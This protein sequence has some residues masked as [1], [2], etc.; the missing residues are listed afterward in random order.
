MSRRPVR[1]GAVS[2]LNSRPLVAGLE[3]YP[4]RF[5]VR[6]DVPSACARL[7]HAR[8]TDVG[9][10]P[11]IEYLRGD[12]YRMVPDCAVTSDGPVRSVAIF[13]S[14]PIERVTSLALDTS[15]RTSVALTRVLSEHYF[16]IRPRLVE[17]P[18]VL[19]EMVRQADGALLIGEPALF[20]EYERLGLEKI[21]LG[22]AW[23]QFS[24]LPFVYA[25]WT[26][27]PGALTRDDVAT[28]QEA[29][30]RGVASVDEVA[31]RFFPDDP[32]RAA[33]GAVYLRENIHFRLGP[34]EIAGMER[35]FELAAAT[36]VVP[37]TQPL[38]WYDAP[39]G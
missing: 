17:H 18:P 3:A 12:G 29:R 21:D 14:V 5:A 1:I 22:L 4:E 36:G 35:F 34:R 9:L 37:A 2:Y 24:G 20:A 15:S 10:I 30:A 32:D 11:S 25:C 38:R 19:D 7:L 28:L 27:H 39:G 33:A 23:Q 8:E 13:T 26:G 6:Y 16:G 31:A